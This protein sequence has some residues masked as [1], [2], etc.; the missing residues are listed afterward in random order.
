MRLRLFTLHSI[1]PNAKSLKIIQNKQTRDSVMQQLP[2]VE[3]EFL[4]ELSSFSSSPFLRR[5]HLTMDTA[6]RHIFSA[7]GH[8]ETLHWTSPAR[9]T[10]KTTLHVI[11]LV[12]VGKTTAWCPT[13]VEEGDKIRHLREEIR[14]NRHQLKEN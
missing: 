9:I 12:W 8:K 14:E 3:Y 7:R 4:R 2:S 11:L 13:C 5:L 6:E 10:S 1:L